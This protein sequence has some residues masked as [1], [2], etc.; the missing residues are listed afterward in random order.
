MNALTELSSGRPSAAPMCSHLLSFSRKS[1]VPE[2]AHIVPLRSSLMLVTGPIDSTPSEAT[3]VV[4]RRLSMRASP[5]PPPYPTQSVPVGATYSERIGRRGRG[6]PASPSHD[7]T[8]TPSNRTSPLSVPSHRNPL[9]SWATAH[10]GP[11]RPSL[12]LNDVSV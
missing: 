1:P 4:T 7:E 12:R 6:W 8:R 2:E 11:T 5:P 9:A 3:N 10:T